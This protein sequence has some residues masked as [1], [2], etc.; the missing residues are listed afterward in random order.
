MAKCNRRYV[1]MKTEGIQK[2]NPLA[3]ELKELCANNE[4][5]LNFETSYRKKY[6]TTSNTSFRDQEDGTRYEEQSQPKRPKI[7]A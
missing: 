1:G 3:L 6:A 4:R 5:R 7:M 2:F